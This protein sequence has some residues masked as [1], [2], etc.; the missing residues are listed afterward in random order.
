MDVFSTEMVYCD[1]C[2]DDFDR[3]R[4]MLNKSVTNGCVFNRDGVLR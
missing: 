2:G 3:V 4:E 1:R